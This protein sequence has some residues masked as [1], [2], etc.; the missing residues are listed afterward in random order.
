M[1]KKSIKKI[2]EIT[3]P[4]YILGLFSA[5]ITLLIS[6]YLYNKFSI[7][8]FQEDSL[9]SLS[10]T[11]GFVTGILMLISSYLIKKEYYNLSG[12]IMLLSSS[13][14]GLVFGAGILI[15]PVLGIIGGMLGMMEH[16]KLIKKHL[17]K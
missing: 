16:E 7:T 17:I 14:I 13:I 4:S 5:V 2:G 9:I 6:L 11:I 1:T 10:I 8:I 15:G 12:S 3:K